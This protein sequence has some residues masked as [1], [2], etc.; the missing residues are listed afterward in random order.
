MDDFISHRLSIWS[1]F[2]FSHH[3][4]KLFSQWVKDAYEGARLHYIRSNQANLRSDYLT[5]L[6]DHLELGGEGNVGEKVIL[7]SP[8]T[9][10]PGNMYQN[11]VD[12]MTMVNRHFLSQ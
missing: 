3:T 9:G 10:S 6:T 2:S 12:A 4:Q 1:E 7:Y 5:N 8:F 11:Y